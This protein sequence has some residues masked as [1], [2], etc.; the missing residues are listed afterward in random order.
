VRYC[1]LLIFPI[2][3][4]AGCVERTVQVGKRPPR[5]Q[6]ERHPLAT[7]PWND[8]SKEAVCRGV[9]RWFARG[10]DGT[11]A[12]LFVIDFDANPNLYIGL[13]DQDQGDA[14]PFDNHADIH[15]NGLGSLARTCPNLV[16]AWN[17]LFFAPDH[18][19]TPAWGSHIGPVVLEGNAHY[20]VGS[21]RWTFGWK[22]E[23]GK[24]SFKM[25]H[26]PEFK[27]L[28]HQFTYAADGA[29][30]LV[31]NGKP[32]QLAQMPD[33]P[34]GKAGGS[35]PSTPSEAGHIP[36]VD[37][38]RTS[39]TSMGWSKDGHKLFVLIVSEQDTEAESARRYRAGEP[40]G[41]GFTL[42][43]LQAF[44]L[45]YGA[46]GAVNSDGGIVTQCVRRLPGGAYELLPPK[47]DTNGVRMKMNSR[48]DGAPEG[49]TLMTFFVTES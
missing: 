19:K 10:D 13:Y 34:E 27:A 7:W 43:D 8:A 12:E 16:M 9:T 32:L 6:A 39:R 1:W 26:Q 31:L 2:L 25:L 49:G 35:K 11:E 37:F 23:G 29:Q 47:S 41:S 46:W 4:L 18:T 44:W 42:A 21:H 48:F 33:T 45:A 36:V 40:L 30:G 28:E 38:I 14:S 3:A 24:P 22:E 20:N 17:G 15:P 5:S